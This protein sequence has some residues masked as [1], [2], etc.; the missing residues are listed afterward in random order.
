MPDGLLRRLREGG[1]VRDAELDALL[2]PPELCE[3]SPQLWTPVSVALRAAELLV[4]GPETRVLDVGSGVGKLCLIGALSTPASFT[5][6]EH[7]LEWVRIA[8]G[9]AR[10]LGATRARFV[11]GTLDH[12]D[13]A[14]FDAFYLFNPFAE[15]LWSEAERVDR[16]V[17]LSQAR[18]ARDVARAEQLLAATRAGTRVVTFH[19]FG[20]TM[21][22]SY[23][24]ALSEQHGGALEL[25]VKAA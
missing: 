4:A 2:Y 6:I 18:H 24:R 19:G 8:E 22:S 3:L 14:S 21:P 12:V 15:N 16:S 9:A 10:E 23:R 11:H 5:G 13:A 7:R 17:E 1:A 20:G 25:W